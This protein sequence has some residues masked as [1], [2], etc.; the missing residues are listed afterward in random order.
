MRTYGGLPLVA[1]IVLTT[2]TPWARADTRYGLAPSV[3][4]GTAALTSAS[5][6][7]GFIGFTALG[8][9]AMGE[10]APWGGFARGDF[11]SSGSDGR[12]TALTLALGPS[13]R[14]FG[15]VQ[16]LSLV[17]RAGLEYAHWHASTGGCT[18]DLFFPNGCKV[19]TPPNPNGTPQPS[20]FDANASAIGALVG[21]RLEL[22][23]RAVYAA[24]DTSLSPM[25]GFDSPPGAAFALQVQLVFAFRDWRGAGAEPPP[26]PPPS[27]GPSPRHRL[28]GY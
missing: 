7:P 13:Y 6:L 9:E 8:L 11:L 5:P 14:I 20:P 22:P 16:H 2:A 19:A 23:V 25:I 24:L 1:A 3:G 28:D 12:W 10:S 27:P 4:A 18:V 15:D 21:A 17:L 26:P